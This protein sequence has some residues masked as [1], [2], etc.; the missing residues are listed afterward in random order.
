MHSNMFFFLLLFSRFSR[1]LLNFLHI[2]GIIVQISTTKY[3]C[4]FYIMKCT[5]TGHTYFQ[6]FFAKRKILFWTRKN[7]FFSFI[8]FFGKC[9]GCLRFFGIC[10]SFILHNTKNRAIQINF[11]FIF[12]I[13]L[14]LQ[15]RK[16]H[17]VHAN[18]S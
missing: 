9:Y 16:K 13:L 17:D 1:F 15:K 2:H 3:Y 4:L 7:I 12:K 6:T 10:F 8:D 5:V 14:R 18:A 11:Q